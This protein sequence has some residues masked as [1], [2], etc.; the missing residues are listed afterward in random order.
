MTKRNKGKLQT[1]LTPLQEKGAVLLSTGQNVKDIAKI[2]DV[3][4]STLW[5]WRQI[6]AFEA[7][8][9]QL[10]EENLQTMQDGIL[11]LHQ[12]A[13]E[14]IKRCLSTDNETIALKAALVIIEKGLQ[15]HVGETDTQKIELEQEIEKQEKCLEASIAAFC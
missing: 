13:L 8:L 2:L 3:D 15:V 11:N 4:R 10:R 14:T 6:P 9:N 7:N 5:Y 1:E 12:Q